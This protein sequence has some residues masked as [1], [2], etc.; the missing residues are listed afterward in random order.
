MKSPNGTRI[1]LLPVLLLTLVLCFVPSAAAWQLGWTTPDSRG[2][3]G[4]GSE[5]YVSGGLNCSGCIFL[6]ATAFTDNAGT[7]HEVALLNENDGATVAPQWEY[8]SSSCTGGYCDTLF[9][10]CSV[11]TGTYYQQ[12]IYLYTQIG[13]SKYWDYSNSGCTS[14]GM[15]GVGSSTSVATSG[16]PSLDMME[17]STTTNSY[18]ANDAAVVAFDPS[19]EYVN[20]GG[21]LVNAADAAPYQNSP[22]TIIGADYGCPTQLWIVIE[23]AYGG[24]WSQGTVPTWACGS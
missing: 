19:L 10:G 16:N 23:S 8:T 9:T 12:N 4:V 2:Q 15:V 21:T 14:V 24:P 17:S 7:W 1:I 20:T 18:F 22:L 6:A 5:A 13:G 11:T 3:H